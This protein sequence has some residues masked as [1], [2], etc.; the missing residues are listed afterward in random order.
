MTSNGKYPIRA[1]MLAL[2]EHFH[3]AMKMNV[4][5]PQNIC[6]CVINVIWYQAQYT[7]LCSY[8]PMAVYIYIRIMRAMG[9][10]EWPPNSGKHKRCKE[11]CW[12]KFVQ[13]SCRS[14]RTSNR[15]M[16]RLYALSNYP[17]LSSII[18][19]YL[20]SFHRRQVWETKHNVSKHF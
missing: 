13:R 4:N 15:Y 1:R 2:K 20:T 19:F 10:S 18:H 12:T 11:Y 17:F 9:E 16:D 6:L 7:A 5:L 3:C 14:R 8:C